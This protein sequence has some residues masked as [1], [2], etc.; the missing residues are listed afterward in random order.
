MSK[1]ELKSYTVTIPIAGHAFVDVEAAN[2]EE[3]KAKAFD[4][5][6]REHIQD[7]EALEEINSGNVCYCPLPWEVEV[8]EQ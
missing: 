4:T 7:W 3:A 8:E 6:T 1:Q 2:E 5:V